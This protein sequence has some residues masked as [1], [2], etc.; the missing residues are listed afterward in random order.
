MKIAI[1]TD[2]YLPQINGVAVSTQTFVKEFEKLGHSVVI[3]GPKVD[4]TTRSTGRVWRF[5]SMPFPFQTEHRIIFPLSR[6]LRLFKRMG[7]DIIHVQT[8]FFMG[9]LGQYL[10]WKNNIPVVHTYHTFWAEY[11]HYFPL[12]PKRLRHRIDLLLLSKNFCNRCDHVFVPTQ[13][14]QTKLLEY[15]VTVPLTILPTGINLETIRAHG[16]PHDFRAK[17]NIEPQEKVVIFVGRLGQEKNVRFLMDA[18]AALNKQLP[19][20]RLLMVGDGPEREYLEE[21]TKEL[22]ISNHVTFCGYLPHQKVFTAYA[23][24]DVIAFPSKTETQGLSLLEGLALGKPAV[25]INELGVKHILTEGGFLTD[26]SLDDYVEKLV[27][28]LVDE[29]LYHQKYLEAIHR[30]EQFSANE[31]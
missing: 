10:G 26:D 30:G 29:K 2:T 25:C 4:K 6:K 21:K 28:L 12:I 11:L 13:E 24:S 7:F 20:T 8:P 31:M 16:S 22:G 18:F 17:Y 9:H 3:I 1:F 14:I 15:G 23:A 27:K 19:R 5:K